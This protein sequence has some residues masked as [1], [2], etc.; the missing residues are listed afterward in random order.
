MCD[1]FTLVLTCVEPQY[2][3]ES[4][5]RVF[6]DIRYALEKYPY[7]VP[8]QSETVLSHHGNIEKALSLCGPVCVNHASSTYFIPID[9]FIPS[10]YPTV[11]PMCYVRPAKGKLTLTLC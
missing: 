7:L 8:E 6:K 3:P 2:P 5:E 4:Q 10:V 1:W 9:L 11:P